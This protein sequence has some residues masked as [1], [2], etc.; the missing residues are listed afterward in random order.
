MKYIGKLP[1]NTLAN[2]CKA[3]G[4]ELIDA[5]RAMAD[6]EANAELVK[7]YLRSL[8]GS[9]SAVNEDV[10]LSGSGRIRSKFQF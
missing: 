2:A 3:N 1:D 7:S 10:P 9:G 6:V 5:H 8:R 4:I